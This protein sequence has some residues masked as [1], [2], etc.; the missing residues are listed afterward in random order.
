MSSYRI[1]GTSY[2]GPGWQFALS[3][4]AY[5]SIPH[6]LL[7]SAGN[8]NRIRGHTSTNSS[9]LV[10]A[11]ESPSCQDLA[12]MLFAKIRLTC[13]FPSGA[14]RNLKGEVSDAHQDCFGQPLQK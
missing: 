10:Q 7:G 3:N 9:Q 1:L 8:R 2:P 6:T 12:V 11:G 4:R 14:P 13:V 5:P